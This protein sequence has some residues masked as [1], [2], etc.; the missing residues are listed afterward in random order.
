MWKARARLLQLAPTAISA[1]SASLN[2]RSRCKWKL[3]K[4]WM[5][6][7]SKYTELE[8]LSPTS[9]LSRILYPVP[10]S[11]STKSIDTSRRRG[12]THMSIHARV[13]MI[14]SHQ[15]VIRV[16][17]VPPTTNECSMLLTC[18]AT[19]SLVA[20]QQTKTRPR[21]SLHHPKTLYKS[22]TRRSIRPPIWTKARSSG[23]Y[24]ISGTC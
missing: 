14:T 24:Q 20:S 4:I 11:S 5:R 18:L 2:R 10:V 3:I 9:Q 7:S 6:L 1:T 16:H 23:V 17:S 22:S 15:A 13:L 21:K 12:L 19:P 8:L